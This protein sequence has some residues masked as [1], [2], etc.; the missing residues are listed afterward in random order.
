MSEFCCQ[1]GP[2]TCNPSLYLIV[3]RPLTAP[4]SS[5]MMTSRP[6]RLVWPA[7][8][9][10]EICHPLSYPPRWDLFIGLCNI[11]IIIIYI[12]LHKVGS[13]QSLNPDSPLRILQGLAVVDGVNY[14]RCTPDRGSI[15]KRMLNTKYDGRLT[16]QYATCRSASRQNDQAACEAPIPDSLLKRV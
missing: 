8:V 10:S 13:Y 6:K 3:P 5:P 7:D 2:L 12:Y 1:E 14:T 11:L 4:G 9:W 15:A 16:A